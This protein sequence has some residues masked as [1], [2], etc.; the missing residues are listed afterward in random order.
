MTSLADIQ[1]IGEKVKEKWGRSFYD[2]IDFA[3]LAPV[4]RDYI[5]YD[6]T[7]TNSVTFAATEGVHFGMLTGYEGKK[8][9]PIVMTVP[10]M[11]KAVVLAE[12][13]DEFLGIGFHNGWST[14]EQLV[15]DFEWT[16]EYYS[17]PDG[18]L[19]AERRRFLEFLRVEYDMYPYELYQKR[20][21]EL[22]TKYELVIADAATD[23][24]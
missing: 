15:Y 10:M 12:T 21:N 5:R 19:S 20:L 2:H 7:P 16:I 4:G 22:N 8:L 11:S 9:Q 3:G 23:T 14:L 6:S 17:K 1:K 18:E 24:L 13:F